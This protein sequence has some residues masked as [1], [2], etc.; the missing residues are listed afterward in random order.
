MRNIIEYVEQE[1]TAF[2]EKPFCDVDSLV[3]S[4]LSY[5][6]FEVLL[7]Q[8][9]ADHKAEIR[10]LLRAEDMDLILLNV[11]DP[12]S[13]KKLL[14]AL[15][16]SPRFRN[17]KFGDFVSKTN[18]TLQEQF[19]AVTFYMPDG[20]AYI[21]YRGTDSTLIGWKEDFNMAFMPKVPAQQD[22]LDYI[23]RIAAKFDGYI[24]LCGHSKGGNLAIYSAAFGDAALQDRVRCIYAHDA[25]GF[26][27]ENLQSAGYKRIQY[28]I[29]KTI[30]Q[31]SLI[32]M[33]LENHDNYT[34]VESRQIGIMQHDPFS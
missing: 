19:A 31:A 10:D 3:L 34:V 22:A 14:Y 25:P 13:N 24:N 11:R 8:Y 28:R 26:S 33:L 21:V 9:P 32:G 4:Q 29:R 16:A 18:D 27:K 15:A 20:Q 2:S 12:E 7:N 1:F 6:H 23:N 17:I 30:P 5:I